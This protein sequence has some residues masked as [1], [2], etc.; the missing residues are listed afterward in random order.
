MLQNN[1]YIIFDADP[2]C[3]GP[4]STTLNQDLLT[5]S[6]LNQEPKIIIAGGGNTINK[7]ANL[8]AQTHPHI[9]I[10]CLER[11]DFLQKLHRSRKVLANPGLTTFY[12]CMILNKNVFFLLP[13]NYS[14][15]LQLK[16][17]LKNYYSNEY[18]FLWNREYGYP[19]IPVDLPEKKEYA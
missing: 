6:S 7:L 18:G 16:I 17:Y 19:D 2:F 15:Q 13:Q 1:P 9:K 8:F 5:T 10:G 12:E 3:F 14:Q 11:Q 4:I